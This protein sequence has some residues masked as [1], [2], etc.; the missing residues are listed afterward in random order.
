MHKRGSCKAPRQWGGMQGGLPCIPGPR[1]Q[2]DLTVPSFG[3]LDAAS[4]TASSCVPASGPRCLAGDCSVTPVMVHDA[5]VGGSCQPR[6]CRLQ[7]REV[8]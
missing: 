3:W 8:H 5:G 2:G 6:G 4:S 7:V 1:C